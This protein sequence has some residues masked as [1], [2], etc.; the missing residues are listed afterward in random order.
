MWD[1]AELKDRAKSVFQTCRWPAV[2]VSLVYTAVSGGSS[3]GGSASGRN[4]A[5]SDGDTVSNNVDMGMIVTFLMAFLAVV[6]I[7][8]V[9]GIIFTAF[10]ANP[11]EIGTRRFF[12]MARQGDCASVF[13]CIHSECSYHVFEKYICIFMEPAF[14]YSGHN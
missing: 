6:L 10:V 8:I 5:F 11:I 9:I 2:G 1:R 4:T 3:G 7:A 14:F 13:K 12:M